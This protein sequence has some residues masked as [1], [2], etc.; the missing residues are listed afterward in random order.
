[1]IHFFIENQKPKRQKAK[2]KRH[3]YTRYLVS[4]K[5]FLPGRNKEPEEPRED[6][7]LDELVPAHFPLFFAFFVSSW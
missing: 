5:N 2:I 4:G 1:V 7:T 3:E 6:V